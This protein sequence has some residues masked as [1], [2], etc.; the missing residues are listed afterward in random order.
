[1]QT[2]PEQ[3]WWAVLSAPFSAWFACAAAARDVIGLKGLSDRPAYGWL[4]LLGAIGATAGAAIAHDAAHAAAIVLFLSALAYFAVFDRYAL[5]V[6]VW[7]V[8]AMIALG[9]L[10]ALV[11]YD[12][13]A[14]R[15]RL[16]AALGGWAAFRLL[17]LIYARLRGRSGLG[18][19]DALLAAMIGAWLSADGL[20]WSVAIGCGMALA[21]TLAFKRPKQQALPLAPALAAGA[22][23]VV[24]SGSFS[25]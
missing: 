20:A 24:M 13:S 12:A 1:M 25:E 17:D 21:W 11:L 7:P 16:L 10:V 22:F 18:A 14:L 6:P 8:L 3:Q 23:G 15:D 9:L 5:A 19:G 4:A 2:W